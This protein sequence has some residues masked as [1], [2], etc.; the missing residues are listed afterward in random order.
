MFT[1]IPFMLTPVAAAVIATPTDPYWGNVVL[2]CPFDYSIN[3]VKNGLIPTASGTNIASAGKFNTGLKLTSSATYVRFAASTDW[4]FGTA[5]FTMDFWVTFPSTPGNFYIFDIGSNGFYLHYYGNQLNISDLYFGAFTPTPNVP[6][7]IE[8]SRNGTTLLM[9]VN[10]TLVMSQTIGAATTFGAASV[11]TIGNYGGGG[12]AFVNAIIDDF[13]ITKGVQRNVTNYALP[14]AAAPITGGEGPKTARLWNFDSNYTDAVIADAP[15]T[16]TGVSL[17]TGKFGSGV[18]FSSAA[19]ILKYAA[20]NDFYFGTLPFTIS[21]WLKS[22]S[23]QANANVA[24]VFSIGTDVL[25]LRRDPGVSGLYLVVNSVSKGSYNSPVYVDVNKH[26]EL[27]RSGTSLIL[28]VDG[29]PQIT[30]VVGINESFGTKAPLSIG[31]ANAG[32]SSPNGGVI[33]DFQI[34]KGIALHTAAFTPPTAPYSL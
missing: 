14:T 18:K 10:G 7:Y 6:A 3:D 34:L 21:C 23:A 26:I 13:R 27:V 30:A 32:G 20:S 29:V 11:L 12:Y 15:T 4:A 28:F 17:D 25:S 22:S 16:A 1:Q 9:F 31:C 33:D 2:L 8:I 5:P 24:Y 19:S